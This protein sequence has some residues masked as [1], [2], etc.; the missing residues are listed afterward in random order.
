MQIY[1]F[2]YHKVGT[3]LIQ[4]IFTQI[5]NLFDKKFQIISGKANKIDHTQD[6]V[7]F[8]HSIIDCNL[9]QYPH[10]GVRLIRDPRDVWLSG[11]L[12]HRR[13]AERWC[14]NKN[15][16]TTR[17]ILFPIVPASQ[18]HRP[19]EWKEKYLLS[20]NGKSYQENLNELDKENG[21]NFEMERYADWTISQ[22]IS[23]KPDPDTI[24][25]MIEDFMEDFDGTLTKILRHF[26]F[27][28]DDIPKALEVAA[29]EDI[30]RMSNTQLLNKPHIHSR[31]ISKWKEMINPSQLAI[32]E[33]RY[34]HAIKLLGYK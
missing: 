20:L 6:I 28:E 18:Q 7:Q 29:K 8:I 16:D 30:N 5:A 11:Y 27:K 2:C 4:N 23:W 3:V 22:M 19:E 26:G 15:F 12:Y 34:G 14:I 17:P 31:S 24:D 13:C 32:F 9:S 10:K 1:I 25:I 21:L 33:E